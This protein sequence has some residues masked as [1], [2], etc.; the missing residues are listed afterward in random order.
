MINE[1][2]LA[3]ISLC[4]VKPESANTSRTT[5]N[6]LKRRRRI[7]FEYKSIPLTLAIDS[8]FA[9]LKALPLIFLSPKK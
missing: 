8:K 9:K 3:A 4:K 2:P 7:F 5:N 1:N 6:I